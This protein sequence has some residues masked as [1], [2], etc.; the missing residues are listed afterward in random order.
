MLI[1]FSGLPGVGKTSIAK[2]LTKKMGGVY[3]RIDSIEQAIRNAGVLLKDVGTS[4]YDTSYM[5]AKDNLLLGQTVIADCVNP[6]SWSRD[7]W[8]Q[9]A[10][11][12][13]VPGVDIEIICSDIDEHRLRVESRQSDIPHLALPAWQQIVEKEYQEWKRPRIVIDSA[14]KDIEGCVDEILNHLQVCT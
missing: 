4:G 10:A 13:Q 2:A 6:V 12:A 11:D 1:V 8:M 9:V 5:L 7:N 14:A 3:L